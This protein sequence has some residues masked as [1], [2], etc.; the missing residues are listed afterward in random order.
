MNMQN[1]FQKMML[2][3]LPPILGWA[4]VLPILA[5]SGCGLFPEG[6]FGSRYP[7]NPVDVV[8]EGPL[9]TGVKKTLRFS[10]DKSSSAHGG[11]ITVAWALADKPIGSASVLGN[12]AGLATSFFAD[13]GGY[14]VL[15]ATV[16]DSMGNINNKSVIINA[17]GTGYNHPPVAV[18]TVTEAVAPQPQA[19]P[20]GTAPPPNPSVFILDG[21]MSYDID[22]NMLDFDWVIV[23]AFNSDLPITDPTRPVVF[24]TAY[25]A[26]VKL[27]VFDGIDYDETLVVLPVPAAAGAAP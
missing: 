8:I 16:T 18:V 4:I 7:Y 1:R 23:G 10:A 13:K 24:V 3:A 21:S 6:T 19:P 12:A 14:Y 27:T 15:E 9:E 22:G 11:A 20:G 26:V 17:L 5:L 2:K 25:N